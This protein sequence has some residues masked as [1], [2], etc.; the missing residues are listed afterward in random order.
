MLKMYYSKLLHDK[1]HSSKET[2]S[3][4]NTIK[5]KQRTESSYPNCF[6]NYGRK[7]TDKNDIVNGFNIFFV[8]NDIHFASKIAPPLK[9]ASI[10]DYLENINT[11]SE[12]LQIWETMQ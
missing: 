8:N 2:W 7:S 10:H 11:P 3:I 9:D 4:L 1:K 5:N 12:I 6:R